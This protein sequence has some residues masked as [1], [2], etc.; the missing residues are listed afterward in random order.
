MKMIAILMALLMALTTLT[1]F[2][3]EE[4]VI[5]SPEADEL[6]DFALLE[7]FVMEVLDE[8]ILVLTRDGLYAEAL[9][10]DATVLEGKEIAFALKEA[11]SASAITVSRPG[12][13]QSIPLL[14]EVRK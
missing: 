8:S 13:A 3:E 14:K 10:T 7:G 12:A 4:A 9:L 11:A 6:A 1:A 2:A 5:P